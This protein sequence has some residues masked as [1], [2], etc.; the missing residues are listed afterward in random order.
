MKHTY[1]VTAPD[2]K[3]FTRTSSRI[4]THALIRQNKGDTPYYVSFSSSLKAAQA[5][6]RVFASF[7]SHN[8]I[9]EV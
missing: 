3:V 7:R 9:V 6:S 4:Y 2:G 5:E 8:E 1:A